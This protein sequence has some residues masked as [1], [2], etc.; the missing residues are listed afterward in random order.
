M[1]IKGL[2]KLVFAKYTATG[3][4]VTH[5]DP[6]NNE[7][8]ASYTADFETGDANNLYLDN[9]IAETDGGVF[10]S[11]T[12]EIETGDL[13]NDTSKLLY[14]VKEKEVQSGSS[15]VKELVYDDELKINELG[16]G[17]AELHQLNGNNFYRAIWFPRVRFNIPSDAATTQG[18]NIDWQTKAVTGTI[19]RSAEIS[20]GYVHPWKI[21]ADFQTEAE[22]FAYLMKK[23]GKTA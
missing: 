4:A 10:Q 19:L 2:S 18:E 21:T 1:A 5:A 20:E 9:D 13:S 11:G 17:L 6:V 12:I 15:T 16:V 7:K 8:L 14:S 3:N 23:G 22:A